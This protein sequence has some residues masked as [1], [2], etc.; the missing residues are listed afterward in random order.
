MFVLF[1]ILLM[2]YKVHWKKVDVTIF[3]DPI[4]HYASNVFLQALNS[5]NKTAVFDVMKSSIF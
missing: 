3:F 4:R 2:L 1:N 5:D